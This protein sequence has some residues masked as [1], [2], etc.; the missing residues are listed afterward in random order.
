MQDDDSVL[1]LIVLAIVAAL[2]L[3]PKIREANRKRQLER[4]R[5]EAEREAE[6][7]RFNAEKESLGQK[8]QEKSQQAMPGYIKDAIREFMDKY[9][10]EVRSGRFDEN[11]ISPLTYYGYRVGKARGRPEAERRK[12]MEFVLFKPLPDIFPSS[13]RAKWGKPGSPERL[14]KICNHITMTADRRASRPNYEV[15]VSEWRSDA[16]WCQSAFADEIRVYRRYTV[17]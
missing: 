9:G 15:A 10:A 7:A 13:Y 3:V 14:L 11:A 17:T 16:N 2:F 8:L 1:V 6:R 5:L 4:E 12:I